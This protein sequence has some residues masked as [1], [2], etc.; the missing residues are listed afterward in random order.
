MTDKNDVLKFIYTCIRIDRCIDELNRLIYEAGEKKKTQSDENY[1]F[2]KL[3]R[4]DL[5][6][7]TIKIKQ[8]RTSRSIFSSRNHPYCI[9][10]Q[11]LTNYLQY[12]GRA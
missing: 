8:T 10:N 4:I 5:Y 12:I 3:S 1:I 2:L 11:Q 7:H 6:Y 9:I